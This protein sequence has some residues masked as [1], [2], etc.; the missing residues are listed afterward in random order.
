MSAILIETFTILL[1]ALLL[2]VG[3]LIGLN[4]IRLVLMLREEKLL[5]LVMQRDFGILQLQVQ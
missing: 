3:I 2:M 1:F 5:L 4:S